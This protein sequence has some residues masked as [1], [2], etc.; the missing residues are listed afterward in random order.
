MHTCQLERSQM[1]EIFALTRNGRRACITQSLTA[2][3]HS[4]II[5]VSPILFVTQ[6]NKQE[7]FIEY[8]IV[9]SRTGCGRILSEGQAWFKTEAYHRETSRYKNHQ[10]NGDAP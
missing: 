6:R 5:R 2:V 3:V 4:D 7:A 9:D 10:I 1:T 8:V